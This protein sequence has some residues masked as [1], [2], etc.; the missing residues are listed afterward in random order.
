MRRDSGNASVKAVAFFVLVAVFTVFVLQNTEV[1]DITFFF[2]RVSV[3]RVL[4]L[5]GSGLVGGLAGFFVGWSV[6]TRKP[7]AASR[8]Q[9]E[10]GRP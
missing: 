7:R 5:L 9:S 6:F 3:S 2:W 4:L 1:V 8:P 10:A